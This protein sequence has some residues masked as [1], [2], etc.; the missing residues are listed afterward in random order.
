[1]TVNYIFKRWS[2]ESL[3]ESALSEG[4]VVCLSSKRNL[5]RNTKVGQRSQRFFL[6][7]VDLRLICSHFKGMYNEYSEHKGSVPKGIDQLI[8][9]S[10]NQIINSSINDYLDNQ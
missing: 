9:Y 2:S 6:S 7:L 3:I 4:L 10:M 5:E 8:N 1:M